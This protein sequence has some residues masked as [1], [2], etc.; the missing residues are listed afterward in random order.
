VVV[1]LRKG[2]MFEMLVRVSEVRC[3]KET[4]NRSWTP[5]LMMAPNQDGMTARVAKIAHR[6]IRMIP[7]IHATVGP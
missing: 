4:K 1:S 5:M 2:M 7:M 3:A 6:S